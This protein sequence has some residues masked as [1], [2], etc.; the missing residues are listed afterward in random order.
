MHSLSAALCLNLVT[1][2]SVFGATEAKHD[3]CLKSILTR[4]EEAGLKLSE[5]KDA[6]QA[7]EVLFLRVVI[8][9]HGFNPELYGIWEW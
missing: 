3:V 6:T 7:T 2:V 8:S 5:D 4:L 9:A 1:A